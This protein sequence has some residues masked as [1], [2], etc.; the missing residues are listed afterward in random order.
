MFPPFFDDTAVQGRP[1]LESQIE[2]IRREIQE[3]GASIVGGKELRL[4]C[5]DM[6]SPDNQWEAVAKIAINESWSFTFFPNHSVR[7]AKL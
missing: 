3:N 1:Q 5:N 4:L 2:R 6:I 7:F